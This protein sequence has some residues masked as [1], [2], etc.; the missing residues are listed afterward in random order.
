MTNDEIS[1]EFELI[2]ES[3]SVAIARLNLFRAAFG[4]AT[5]DQSIGPEFIQEIFE[6]LSGLGRTKY[7][8]STSTPLSRPTA[9]AVL[10]AVLCLE[11]AMA[12]GGEVTAHEA[13]GTWRVDGKSDRLRIDDS[14]WEPLIAGRAPDETA[15]NAVQFALL[16][17][18]AKDGSMSLQV[19]LSDTH[20]TIRL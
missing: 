16:P 15:A 20:I 5:R 11:T 18:A 12:F 1:P 10:L 17:A 13:A 6:S 7:N 19:E 4:K 8:L 14:L 9:K 3:V 2:S